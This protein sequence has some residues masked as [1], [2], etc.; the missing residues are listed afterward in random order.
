MNG[1]RARPAS[2][3][4]DDDAARPLLYCTPNGQHHYGLITI[5]CQERERERYDLCTL[6]CDRATSPATAG[7]KLKFTRSLCVKIFNFHAEL[8][9]CINPL[10]WRMMG[11]IGRPAKTN[12]NTDGRLRGHGG[13]GVG[14]TT[15]A[16]QRARLASAKSQPTRTDHSNAAVRAQVQ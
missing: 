1:Q 12:N 8:E 14:A 4:D 10:V 15:R 16:N 5:G 11:K 13:G 9:S 2:W 7:R 3:D 6:R